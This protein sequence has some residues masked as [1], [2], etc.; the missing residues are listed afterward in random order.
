MISWQT[1]PRSRWP[2][3][4]SPMRARLESSQF[5]WAFSAVVSRRV[6]I[7]RLMLSLRS[8]ISPAAATRISWV[9]SPLATDVATPE[10]A[11]SCERSEEHTS[12]LQSR[13]DL[14]CRLLLEKK[15]DP[16]PEVDQLFDEVDVLRFQAGVLR[17]D[18]GFVAVADQAREDLGIRVGDIA[19]RVTLGQSED[20]VASTAEGGKD[21]GQRAHVGHLPP[22]SSS[23]HPRPPGP[24][25]SRPFFF[26]CCCARRDLHSFPTRRSSD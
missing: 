12:E 23:E 8:A 11:R 1:S 6:A 21:R 18:L 16:R 2:C 22:A 20:R 17:E 7:I 3:S 10:I 5:C 24:G 13:R 26:C 4:C 19:D 9:R 14:V 15:N 25:R